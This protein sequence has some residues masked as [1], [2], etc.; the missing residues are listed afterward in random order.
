[1]R[2]GCNSRSRRRFGLLFAP[3]AMLA[4]AGLAPE[5]AHAG[6]IGSGKT[7]Q[8]FYYNVVLASPEGEINQ[9]SGTSNPASLTVPVHF[10]QGAASGS[11]IAVTDTQIAITNQLSGPFCFANTPGTN[12]TD[13]IDGFDFLFTGEDILGVSVDGSTPSSFLPVSGAFQGNTHLGLQLLSADEIRVDVTGDLPAQF[14][15]LTL[16]LSFAAPPP[17]P[18]PPPP[19]AGVPEPATLGLFAAA[20]VG[21][22]LLRRHRTSQPKP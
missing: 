6:L 10:L 5:Q 12:C 2:S 7:V 21:L 20:L 8:A 14:A 22:G 17:P 13:A 18:P 9:A 16:D 11:T 4:L 19:P 1:M 15:A 3:A